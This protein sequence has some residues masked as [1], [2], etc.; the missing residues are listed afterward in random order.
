MRYLALACLLLGVVG[1]AHSQTAVRLPLRSVTLYPN[2]AGL[3]HRGEVSLPAGPA[4]VRLTGLSARL[5]GPSVQ[6]EVS[7]AE[8]EGFELVANPLP[9]PSATPVSL[10]DSLR[11]AQQALT[12]LTTESATIAAEVEFLRQNVSLGSVTPGKWVEETQRAAAYYSTRL[13]ALAQRDATVKTQI[14][15]QTTFITALTRRTELVPAGEAIPQSVVLRLYLARASTVRL[16]VSYQL[17]NGGD[18]GWGPE[19]ELRVSDADPTHLRVVSRARLTNHTGL[20]WTN[21]PVDL[22][23]VA[24]AAD[25]SR[26]A[27]EPWTLGLNSTSQGEGLLDAFAVKGKGSTSTDAGTGAALDLGA[28]LALSAP[29]TLPANTIRTFKLAEQTLPLRLEYLA[30]PKLDAQVFLVGRV[31][32]WSR[33]NFLTETAKVFYRGAY[34]GETEVDTRAYA[35]TLEVSLGRDPQVQLTRTKREDVESKAAISGRKT[36]KLGYEINVKN[37]HSYPVPLRLLDQIPVAQDKEII[38]KAQQT[39]GATLDE[40]SGK[41]TWLFT[42]PAGASRRL[43]FAFT[44]ETPANHRANLRRNR[45]I[46]SPKY[47]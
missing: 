5:Y 41:L 4:E 12:R 42:L 23:T 34:V 31:T 14:T 36:T 25:V 8:L 24:P 7:G 44:V 19:Y 9:A 16:D 30:V 40:T 35:D 29:V 1:H 32:D 2:G 39:S 47:R 11:V 45:Q 6:P 37:L 20:A 27:L 10:T 33:V 43:P 18:S 13:A 22:R 26:P 17:I 3:Y 15:R 21:V 46:S 38:V 28:Q